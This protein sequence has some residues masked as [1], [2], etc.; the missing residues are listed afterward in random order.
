M[1][2]VIEPFGP[3]GAEV[4][5]NSPTVLENADVLKV[6]QRAD[7]SLRHIAKSLKAT[8]EGISGLT[9]TLSVGDSRLNKL[10]K[11]LDEMKDLIVSVSDAQRKQHN[12]LHR[13]NEAVAQLL[14]DKL[15]D[16]V[17]A[18]LQKT[19]TDAVSMA[20]TTAQRLAACTRA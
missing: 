2:G 3:I 19:H 13:E 20:K 9:T 18:S 14:A 4:S 7:A 10:E 11:R 16:R 15:C 12:A 8:H 17:D 6:V 1:G 5:D